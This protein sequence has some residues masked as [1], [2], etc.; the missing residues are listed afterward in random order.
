[1][2]GW[3]PSDAR[4]Q[5]DVA[6]VLKLLQ[7]VDSAAQIH[8]FAW[9]ICVAGC[10]AVGDVQRDEFA[11]ILAGMGDPQLLSAVRESGR[12]MKA[13]WELDGSLVSESWDLAACFRILGTPAPLV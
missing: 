10:L 3:V 7:A 5:H 11:S 9:P 6:Q 4:I 2:N 8:T 12:I 1:M 13:I